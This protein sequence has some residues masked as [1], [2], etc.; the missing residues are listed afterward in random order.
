[1]KSPY[2]SYKSPRR[3]GVRASSP[4]RVSPSLRRP[5]CH[6]YSLTPIS[7][8]GVEFSGWPAGLDHRNPL[9]VLRELTLSDLDVSPS[10]LALLSREAK[11]ERLYP[12]VGLIGQRF[13]GCR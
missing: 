2:A 13:R 7:T 10:L 9:R 3:L 11:R 12:R 5:R 6:V 1:M 8:W 4:C